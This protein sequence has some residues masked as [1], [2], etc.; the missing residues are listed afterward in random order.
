MGD[1]C[2]K[3]DGLDDG[4]AGRAD[5]VGLLDKIFKRHVNIAPALGKQACRAR[6]KINSSLA[7]QAV[8]RADGGD[9]AP[10]DE[11]A[12]DE[13]ASGMLANSAASDMARLQRGTRFNAR[14][15][16]QGNGGPGGVSVLRGPPGR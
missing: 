8:I 1:A 15:V 3:F 14:H 6:V 2:V 9:A 7:G 4:R 5:N 10:F 16:W 12:F 13:F 11:F